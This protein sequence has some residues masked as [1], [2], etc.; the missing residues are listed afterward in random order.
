MLQVAFPSLEYIY[1]CRC[2]SLRSMFASSVARELKQL[3]QIRVEACEEMTSIARVDEQAI[4]DGILFPELTC[5]VLYNLPNLMSFWSN[6]N[7][8]ADTCKVIL[9]NLLIPTFI[10]L[11][12]YIYLACFHW[13]GWCECWRSSLLLK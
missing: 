12:H 8:K 6:Q 4:C 2:G 3:K 13:C 9:L 5:L 11:G 7:G 1:I 10:F